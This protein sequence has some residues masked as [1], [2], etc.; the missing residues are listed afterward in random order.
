MLWSLRVPLHG[1]SPQPQPLSG[2]SECVCVCVCVCVCFGMVEVYNQLSGGLASSGELLRGGDNFQ[3][4]G[5]ARINESLLLGTKM[6][7]F[8]SYQ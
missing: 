8:S 5:L 1:W 4:R 7:H 3:L 2:N 6:N